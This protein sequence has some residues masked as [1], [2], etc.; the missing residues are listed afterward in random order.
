[1]KSKQPTHI[2]LEYQHFLK[3]RH[4][5]N[6]QKEKAWNKKKEKELESYN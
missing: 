5:N 6:K 3:V 1:M 4:N 2:K